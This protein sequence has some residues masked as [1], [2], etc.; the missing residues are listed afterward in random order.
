MIQRNSNRLLQLAI[1]V[2]LNAKTVVCCEGKYADELPEVVCQ[3]TKSKMN[4]D[5]IAANGLYA[6]GPGG[7]R[8]EKYSRMFHPRASQTHPPE[9]CFRKPFN[10][11][12][13]EPFVC[14][15]LYSATRT[16]VAQK[17]VDSNKVNPLPSCSV[18][19]Q[20]PTKSLEKCPSAMKQNK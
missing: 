5:G 11:S 15:G 3:S 4:L 20:L 17:A 18:V 10:K 16:C 6:A 1:H 12:I 13:R 14:D 8:I 2:F 19:L 9:Y 7:N